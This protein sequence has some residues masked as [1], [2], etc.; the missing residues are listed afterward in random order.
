M[1]S[2]NRQWQLD[3]FHALT[4]KLAGVLEGSRV[5]DVGCGDGNGL[6]ALLAA[7][8]SRGHVTGIDRDEPSLGRV[9]ER[10]TP[11]IAAGRLTTVHA[12]IAHPLPL[13]PESFD[14]VICQNMIEGVFNRTALLAEL[15]RVLRAGGTA[16]VAHHDFDGAIVA[17]DDRDLTRRLVHGYADHVDTWQDTSD[18]Q[19]GRLLPGLFKGHPFAD[20]STETVLF[21]DLELTPGTYAHRYL[22]NVVALA[23]DFGVADSVARNWF[24]ALQ[25]RS[26]AGAFYCAVPWTY[27]V[28][29]RPG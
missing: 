10:F 1:R 3:S 15:W 20:C 8:G 24:E 18:G 21:V 9:A 17:S 29:R 7:A 26:E 25:L 4:A 23:N 5:L 12:D 28:A 6:A 22:S 11:E 27:V 16:L 14:A 13:P 2:L 19:M